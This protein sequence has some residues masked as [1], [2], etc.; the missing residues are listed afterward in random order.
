MNR[1]RSA[2]IFGAVLSLPVLWMGFWVRY[3]LDVASHGHG[4]TSFGVVMVFPG[5]LIV[6]IMLGTMASIVLPDP[7]HSPKHILRAI[8]WLLTGLVWSGIYFYFRTSD[9]RMGPHGH[10]LGPSI[11]FWCTLI[12]LIAWFGVLY[13]QGRRVRNTVPLPPRTL[14][15]ARLRRKRLEQDL[16]R[17]H[18]MRRRPGAVCA[19]LAGAL[20]VLSCFFFMPADPRNADT[21]AVLHAFGIV[22][23]IAYLIW[24]V[25]FLKT[26]VTGGWKQYI[27]F[28]IRQTEE[29]LSQV[30]AALG[31]LAV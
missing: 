19:L 28:Y 16:A 27:D 2:L 20:V 7:R 13:R 15:Q 4:Q 26:L 10:T 3:V 12:A 11:L 18:W 14:H 8:A 9:R 1:I 29:R 31:K 30:D 21:L 25:A 24:F 5:S 17:L 6:A 22:F 23:G